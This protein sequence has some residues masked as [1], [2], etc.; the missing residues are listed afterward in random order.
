MQEYNN[1]ITDTLARNTR[2][3]IASLPQPLMFGGKRARV[4]PKAGTTQY[5]YPGTLAVGRFSQ[6]PRLLG[7][8]FWQDFGKGFKQGAVGTA[9]VVAPIAGELAKDA[10]LSYIRGGKRKKYTL[11]S[12]AK[13]LG[14]IAQPFKE[15]VVPVATGIAKEV[16]R[17]AIKSYLQG[18]ALIKN[19][20]QEFHSDIYPQALASYQPPESHMF[21][22][23][24][25]YYWKYVKDYKA[26]H[27][28]LT[29]EE[30]R[31]RIRDKHSS[32]NYKPEARKSRKDKKTAKD[33]VADAFETDPE[34]AAALLE[35]IMETPA[36]AKKG[37]RLPKRVTI[38]AG[39]MYNSDSDS[40]DEMYGGDMDYYWKA[41]KK[42]AAADG[43]PLKKARELITAAIKEKNFEIYKPEAR[44]SRKENGLP[45]RVTI[46]AGAMSGGRGVL[47]DLVKV[48]KAAA[49]YVPLMMMAAGRKQLPRSGH[50]R[51]VA[52]G[53]IVAAVMR[54]QGISLPAASRYVKDNGL[55]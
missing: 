37:K 26:K 44:K 40:D 7:A 1:G 23:D 42:L 53:D 50:K 52:R 34:G 9:K 18:G 28:E 20:P 47:D 6:T 27:P 10:A 36:K 16:A 39:A 33:I 14:D 17:D 38:R 12:F 31:G 30:I 24:M 22:G 55:Y 13:D 2:R 54:Q 3:Q 43:I 49:P 19:R 25:A 35:T 5:D 15:Q 32:V 8:G 48:S 29:F 51:E 21:G 45:K 46:R 41:V 11:G 4:H